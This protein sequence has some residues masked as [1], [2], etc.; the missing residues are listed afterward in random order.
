MKYLQKKII[1]LERKWVD[2]TTFIIIWKTTYE[3]VEE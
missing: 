1:E 3:V 2:E